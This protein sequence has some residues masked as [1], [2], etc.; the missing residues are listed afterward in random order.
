MLTLLRFFYLIFPLL[1]LDS[2]VVVADQKL[3]S[4]YMVAKDNGTQYTPNDDVIW[5]RGHKDF[6]IYRTNVGANPRIEITRKEGAGSFSITITLYSMTNLLSDPGTQLE[7][8]T[9]TSNPPSTNTM[10]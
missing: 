8:Q 1:L 6:L 5:Y 2:R 4:T 3:G 9:N 7:Q 10:N